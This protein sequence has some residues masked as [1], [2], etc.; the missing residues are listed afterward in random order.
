MEQNDYDTCL[1]PLDKAG[2]VF[3]GILFGHSFPLGKP[4]AY[5]SSHFTSS[6]SYYKVISYRLGLDM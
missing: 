6:F 4:V 2:P 5:E 3:S 1:T